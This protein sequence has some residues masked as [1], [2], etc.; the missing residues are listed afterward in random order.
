MSHGRCCASSVA[1]QLKDGGFLVANEYVGP[2]QFQWGEKQ[3]KIIND[4]L[5]ILPKSRKLDSRTGV[6]KGSFAGPSIEYMNEND[7]SEAIRSDEIVGYISKHLDSAENIESGGNM[8]HML[9][10]GEI[11][12]FD[13]EEEDD[14]ALLRLL[15]PIDSMLIS[16]KVMPSDF[17]VIVARKKEK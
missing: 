16:E 6:L 10:D 14:V 2:S 13:E 1:H 7:P 17:A 12:N 8:L 4:L 11:S 3:A 9:L 15:S 5:K